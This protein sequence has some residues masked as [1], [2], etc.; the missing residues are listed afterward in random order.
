MKKI[1]LAL[2]ISSLLTVGVSYANNEVSVDSFYKMSTEER[3]ENFTKLLVKLHEEKTIEDFLTKYNLVSLETKKSEL[4]YYSLLLSGKHNPVDFIDNEIVELAQEDRVLS[5]TPQKGDI[6]PEVQSNNVMSNPTFNDLYLSQQYYMNSNKEYSG[7]SSILAALNQK[8]DLTQQPQQKIRIAVI[9]TGNTVHN[10]IVYS[11]DS[12]NFSLLYKKAANDKDELNR[13]EAAK[14]VTFIGATE[15]TSGH[16][17]AVSHVISAL[18][19][20]TQGT[21]GI[22]DADIIGLRALAYDCTKPSP[23]PEGYESDTIRAILWASGSAV[24]NVDVLIPKKVDVINL[25]L[26]SISNCSPALQSAINVATSN[27]IIVVASAGN[28]NINA[29]GASPANCQGVITVASNDINGNKSSFSN[30]GSSVTLSALGENIVTANKDGVSYDFSNGTSFSAPIVSGI[31]GLLKQ[32][33]NTLNQ[34]EVKDILVATAAKHPMGTPQIGSGVVD[35]LGAVSYAD[36]IKGFETKAEHLYNNKN[37]CEDTKYIEQMKKLYNVCETYN[38]E[39]TEKSRFK[40]MTYQVVSKSSDEKEWSKLNTTII[41]SIKVEQGK[42]KVVYRLT[43]KD[44]R[45]SY[46]IRICDLGDENTTSDDKCYTV[47]EIDFSSVEKPAAC[48]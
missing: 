13:S 2:L 43:D 25:S 36:Q 1:K 18:R 33:Y 48:N 38:I 3:S 47:S 16:G 22:I 24:T 29:S 12:R 44:D 26:G 37:S 11:G 23:V 30:F 8:F 17:A 40:E 9:D 35:A 4:G 10:D 19:N 45:T 5:F 6:V 34:S 46:G 31:S 42:Q 7:A 32:R 28:N 14:D 15:C 27:G 21:A 39:L 41:D 20:N